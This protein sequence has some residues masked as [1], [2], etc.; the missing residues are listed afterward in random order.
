MGGKTTTKEK[1]EEGMSKELSD[2]DIAIGKERMIHFN[3][4]QP[5]HLE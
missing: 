3:F 5:Y 4:S 1:K 2:D